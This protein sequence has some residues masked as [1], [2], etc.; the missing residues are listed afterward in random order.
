MS[1]GDDK[2]KIGEVTSTGRTREVRSTAQVSE[3][4]AVRGAGAVDRVL[5]V[6]G[7]GKTSSARAITSDQRDRLMNLVA[8]EAEKLAKDGSI[9]KSQRDVV[10]RAVKMVIE[11]AL[12][13]GEDANSSKKRS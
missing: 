2:K 3:V 9:P 1:S 8:Q 12:I 11:A 10:E 7:V 5:G 4:E 6:Q 13:D